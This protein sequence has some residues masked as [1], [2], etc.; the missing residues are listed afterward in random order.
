MKIG[1]GLPN[2]A[3]GI[4]A[5]RILVDLARRAEAFGFSS[6]ATIGR[7]AYPNYEE[8]VTLAAAAAA[9]ER[10][11][12]FTD[13]LLGPAREPVLLAKQAASLDQISGGRFVLGVGVG[14]RSDDFAV[15]GMDFHTRGKRFDAALQVMH[16]A[17]RGEPV[18]GTDVAVTPRPVNGS[19]VPM[20][21]GGGSDQ[22]LQR[23]L[24]YGIGFTQGGGT[25]ES[26]QTAMERIGKAWRAAGREGE[27]RYQ[28]LVYFVLG[29][30]AQEGGERSIRDYYGAYGDRVWAGAVK[31][32]EEARARVAAYRAVGCD[33][34]VF[35]A[36]APAVA[37]AE[38]LA[39]AV[40]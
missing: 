8:L 32:P 26:L 34:L 37:Q 11:G 19:S 16:S 22:S 12:L 17:W 15:T 10:I 20:L 30:D 33:E 23:L 29:D 39:E 36:A 2:T 13:I 6:L 18:P 3:A 31:D 40:L 21:F 5:G 9:T 1:L 4:P 24:R 35:F 28:A 38:R 14:N 25:P 27:P 7:V